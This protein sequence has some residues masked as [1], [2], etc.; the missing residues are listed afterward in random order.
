MGHKT[1][2]HQ[3]NHKNLRL[4]NVSGGTMSGGLMSGGLM[5]GYPHSCLTSALILQSTNKT[6]K[7]HQKHNT[8][9]TKQNA[10]QYQYRQ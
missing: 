1:Q 9:K 3:P 6:K 7:M 4:I 5:S 10:A 8:Q 2:S